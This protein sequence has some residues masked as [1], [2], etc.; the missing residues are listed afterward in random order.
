MIKAGQPW[1]LG[2]VEPYRDGG[3]IDFATRLYDPV[4]HADPGTRAS[5]RPCS[6]SFAAKDLDKVPGVNGAHHLLLDGNGVVIAS[7][8]PKRPPGYHFH[9]PTQIDVLT[10]PSGIVHGHYFD[11]VPLGQH[12]LEGSAGGARERVLRQRLGQPTSGC[13]G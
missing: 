6:A 1:A 9:T 2:N 7:T 5:A 12:D 8:N 13:R 4:R 10:H 3:V 11:Q